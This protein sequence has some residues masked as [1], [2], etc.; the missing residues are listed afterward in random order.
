MMVSGCFA[1]SG[2][3]AVIDGTWILLSAGGCPAITRVMQQVSDPK[4]IISLP[5]S[6]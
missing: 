1:A 3:L 4:H 6:D 2:R 5:L